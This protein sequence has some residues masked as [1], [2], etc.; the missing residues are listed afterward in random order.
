MDPFTQ[1]K[2]THGKHHST[3]ISN[4][5]GELKPT[6]KCIKRLRWNIYKYI[7]KFPFKN[8]IFLT[9]EY[10]STCKFFKNFAAWLRFKTGQ[11][12]RSAVMKISWILN[13]SKDNFVKKSHPLSAKRKLSILLNFPFL[14]VSFRGVFLT[15]KCETCSL[16]PPRELSHFCLTLKDFCLGL[17]FLLGPRD[18]KRA[19]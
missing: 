4:Q 2:S 11:G 1:V 3:Q 16:K 18:P 6:S 7:H 12:L 9:I 10:Q 17:K 15:L 14:S 8:V 13:S 19:E 5:D